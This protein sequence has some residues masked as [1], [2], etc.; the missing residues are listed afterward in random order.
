MEIKEPNAIISYHV[1]RCLAQLDNIYETRLL[2]WTIAKA[3][4]VLK[5]YNKDLKD[6]NVEHAMRVTRLTIPSR[7][8]LADGDKNYANITKAFSL[9]DKKI[10]YERDGV[11]YHLSIIALPE[12]F[13]NGAQSRVTFIIHSDLWHAFLDF[14]K[15]Y[16][17]FSMSTFMRL[18][19]T[20][21]VILYLLVSQQKGPITMTIRYLRTLLGCDKLKSYDRGYNFFARIIDPARKELDD[22][23]PFSFEYSADRKGRGGSYTNIVISPRLSHR[24]KQDKDDDGKI[25]LILRLRSRLDDGII[26]YL[27][28][29]FALDESALETVEKLLPP[30]WTP[31]QI[32]EHA[33][34]IKTTMLAR[35]VKNR[36]GYYINTLKHL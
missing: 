2:G 1:V 10:I 34:N 15:G 11:E 23:T 33:G 25:R 17:I 30:T 28:D 20:Y 21:S 26:M 31:S 16:R 7:Y 29:S 32:L 13:K 22:K 3:Q 6:I 14:S 24:Y 8:L 36:A 19:S 27:K 18:S 4:S 35:H 9:A 12:L 5:L